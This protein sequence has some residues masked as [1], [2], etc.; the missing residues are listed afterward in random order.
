MTTETPNGGRLVHRRTGS[1]GG[2]SVTNDSS[3]RTIGSVVQANSV[4]DMYI[5]NYDSIP[6]RCAVPRQLPPPVARFVNRT[7]ELDLLTRLMLRGTPE[8]RP[9]VAILSGMSGVGKSATAVQW[10]NAH[11]DR[12]TGGQ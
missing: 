11:A 9:V 10:G 8:L 12:F 5:S 6:V 2:Q 7:R 3:A 4:Q 1:T